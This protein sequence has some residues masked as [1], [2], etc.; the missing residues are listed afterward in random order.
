MRYDI[1]WNGKAV[2]AICLDVL[3][4]HCFIGTSETLQK[5]VTNTNMGRHGVTKDFVPFGSKN[6]IISRKGNS[7]SRRSTLVLLDTLPDDLRAQ[8]L[9]GNTV[10]DMYS[11]PD[12]YYTIIPCAQFFLLV[13]CIINDAQG[14]H[15]NIVVD[16]I[17][18]TFI[19]DY[20]MHAFSYH[21]ISQQPL[22]RLWLPCQ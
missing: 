18:T 6:P 21:V 11:Y 7:Y 8:L 2:L 4:G 3:A 20:S 22:L 16:K 14:C 12:S 10:K 9:E 17:F 13:D 5:K 19:Q 15:N 1:T